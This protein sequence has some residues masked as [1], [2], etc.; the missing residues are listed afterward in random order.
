MGRY[1]EAMIDVDQ[2]KAALLKPRRRKRIMEAKDLLSTGST[3]LNLACTGNVRG[4]FLKGHYYYMVGDSVSGKTW[5]VL[6]CLAEASINKHFARH[7]YIYDG[8]EYGA[9]MAIK[10]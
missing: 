8:C 6:S 5:L 1:A 3:T 10:K 9:L 2:I 4:G 7:R